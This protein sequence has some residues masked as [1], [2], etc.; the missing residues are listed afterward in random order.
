MYTYA[1]NKE[2]KSR[3]VA[4]NVQRKHVIQREEIKIGTKSGVYGTLTYSNPGTIHLDNRKAL[5]GIILILVQIPETD[6]KK[7]LGAKLM[8]NF[9]KNIV[10]GSPCYLDVL[11]VGKGGLTNE[12]LEAWYKK[13]GFA[14]IGRSSTGPVMGINMVTDTAPVPAPVPIPAPASVLAPVPAPAP[15]TGTN[16]GTKRKWEEKGAGVDKKV[17]DY[18]NKMMQ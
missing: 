6:R 13:F 9:M 11:A 15:N 12:G 16:T 1:V 4:N 10:K 3:A 5:T 14:T 8:A 7:G 18:V 2:N 17:T